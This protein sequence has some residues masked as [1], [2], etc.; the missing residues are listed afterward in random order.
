M[1]TRYAATRVDLSELFATWGEP[2]YR[3]NQ[4]FDGLWTQRTPLDEITTLPK[5]LC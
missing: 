4:L 5:P 3:V 2:A 1:T